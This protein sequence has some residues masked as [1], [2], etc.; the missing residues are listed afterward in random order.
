MPPSLDEVAERAVDEEDAEELE[1]RTERTTRLPE[2][3]LSLLAALSPDFEL[4]LVLRLTWLPLDFEDEL[5]L[6]F[7]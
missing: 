1:L 6:R 7:T 5:P 3:D 2:V 4:L